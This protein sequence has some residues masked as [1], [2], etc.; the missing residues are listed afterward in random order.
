VGTVAAEVF[1]V[2]GSTGGQTAVAA[3]VRLTVPLPMLMIAG[4]IDSWSGDELQP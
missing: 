2:G 1:D 3:D 4:W